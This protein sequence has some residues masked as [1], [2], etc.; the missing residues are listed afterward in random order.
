M[1]R[2][3]PIEVGIRRHMGLLGEWPN[4]KL[5]KGDKLRKPMCGPRRSLICDGESFSHV[6]AVKWNDMFLACLLLRP[7]LL[8]APHTSFRNKQ[9]LSWLSAICYACES[10]LGA[11][12]SLFPYPLRFFQGV[13]NLFITTNTSNMH[14]VFLVVSWPVAR[15][16]E[17]LLELILTTRFV[18]EGI[19]ADIR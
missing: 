10:S 17:K 6:D 11:T 4:G 3:G 16:V 12:P 8:N 7:T 9:R 5:P 19:S 13:V 15:F 1:G 18:V 2:G 14:E